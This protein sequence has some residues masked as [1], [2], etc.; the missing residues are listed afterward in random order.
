MKTSQL[1]LTVL[2]AAV[3]AIGAQKL[4]P[5]SAATTTTETAFERV[6]RTGTLRCGWGIW[7]GLSEKDPN[8]GQ[9]SGT[10]HDYVEAMAEKLQLK[11]EWSEEI[12][13]GDIVSSLQSGRID[14]YC[15]GLWTNAAR[16]REMEFVTPVYYNTIYA[17]VRADDTRFD[18]DVM[19]ANDAA[20]TIATIDGSSVG[21]VRQ[22]DFPNAKVLSFSELNSTAETLE[23]VASGKA[24]MAFGDPAAIS[25]YIENNP[26]KVKQVPGMKPLRTF[27]LGIGVPADT[28]L[29]RM[30]D[31]VT[32]E[33]I[34]TGVIEKILQKYESQPGSYLRIA[35]GYVLQ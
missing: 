30:F 28:R 34:N 20:Y 35:P 14:A 6:K 33:L 9:L 23:A 24:D 16:A 18:A 22:H 2:I 7:P 17:Y 3:V 26:G 31:M 1:L 27:P 13:W 32:E 19:K 12:G 10:A 4:L 15:S 8:T 11:V 29:K 25:R 5:Q 21:L